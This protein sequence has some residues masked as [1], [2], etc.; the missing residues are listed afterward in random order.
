M[1]TY[2]KFSILFD[3]DAEQ[4]RPGYSN[5]SSGALCGRARYSL[6][7]I[8]VKGSK[9]AALIKQGVTPEGGLMDTFPW[10]LFAEVSAAPGVYL[11]RLS[12]GGVESVKAFR[13][14]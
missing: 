1:S 13:S 2:S 7:L 11:C 6:S 10:N 3:F 9:F 5:F 14:L 8:D 4:R 12:V